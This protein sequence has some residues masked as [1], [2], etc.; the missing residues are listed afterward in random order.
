MWHVPSFQTNVQRC[1]CCWFLICLLEEHKLHNTLLDREYFKVSVLIEYMK[2]T[3]IR[4]GLSI[5]M[6]GWTN[7]KCSLFVNII[8]TC[9]IVS[10]FIRAI[11]CLGKRKDISFQFKI[12]NDAIEKIGAFNV[13]KIATNSIHVCK[14]VRLWW[15]VLTNAIFGPYLVFMHWNIHWKTLGR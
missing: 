1:N 10:Y 2:Q 15:R 6:D 9:S 13:I 3:W 5:I 7:I 4:D 11:D 8:V 14:L 12:L